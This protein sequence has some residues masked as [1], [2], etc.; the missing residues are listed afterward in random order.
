MGHLDQFAKETFAQ[1][2]AKVTHGA[3]AWQR[4]PELNMSEVRP[5]GLLLVKTPA[6]LAALPPPWSTIKE[7][8]ELILEIKMPG[9][10]LDMTAL[11][12]AVLRRYARQ[13]QRRE[14]ENVRW[15]G[16]EPLWMVAPHVPAILAERRSLESVAPGCYRVGPSPFPFLWIAA[17]ELPL[18]DELIPFLIARS[19]RPLDAFVRWVKTRR[20]INWILHVLECLP[21]S[22]AAHQ[23]LQRYVFL[24]TDDPEIRARQRMIIEWGLE[25]S[26]EIREELT[27]EAHLEEAR[28]A[29]RSVLK[30]RG[31][32]LA[33][34]DEARVDECNVL[35]TLRRWL[36][37]AAVAASTIDALR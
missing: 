4:P 6:V 37:Q 7:A 29:L 11:D 9:D 10:H 23:D 33:A 5:D 18:L 35:D 26:P 15:D 3:A 17:N 19:G 30:A 27:G 22:T 20:S 13:V 34:E 14:D 8:G 25:A 24:K 32:T 28:T 16:E 2:T 21:M 36:N 31:L 1:E 12:R